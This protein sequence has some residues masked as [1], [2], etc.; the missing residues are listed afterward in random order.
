M[1]GQHQQR[2]QNGCQDQSAPNGQHSISVAQS[3]N[4]TMQSIVSYGEAENCSKH[5][6]RREGIWRGFRHSSG[7]KCQRQRYRENS[8]YPTFA[9]RAASLRIFCPLNFHPRGSS[10]PATCLHPRAPARASLTML[11]ASFALIGWVMLRGLA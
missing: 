10:V 8:A 4:A 7:P 11:C 2:D 1:S 6:E 3:V 5:Q 9:P